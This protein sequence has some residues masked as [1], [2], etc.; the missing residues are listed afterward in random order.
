MIEVIYFDGTSSY[1]HGKNA[2]ECLAHLIEHILAHSDYE[3][4]YEDVLRYLYALAVDKGVI[5]KE[6]IE[7]GNVNSHKILNGAGYYLIPYTES[8]AEEIKNELIKIFLKNIPDMENIKK[9]E[10]M[11]FK[12]LDEKLPKNSIVFAKF[13]PDI[14]L[15]KK[16]TRK[17]ERKW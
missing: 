16:T 10:K 3:T 8:N 7:S 9:I 13:K 2:D 5:T 11:T 4:T 15:I 1:I 6:D 17:G 14:E 12:E